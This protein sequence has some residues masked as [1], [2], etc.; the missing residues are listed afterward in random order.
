MDEKK[1]PMPAVESTLKAEEIPTQHIK[2]LYR[3]TQII[4]YLLLVI[5][6]LL[7]FRF[8]L[9]LLG[10]NPTAGFTQFITVITWPFAGPFLNV[11]RVTRVEGSVFEWTTILAMFFYFL[12]ATLIVKLFVMGKPVTTAEAEKKLPEQDKM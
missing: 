10:A 5:E 2:P 4:W 6:I 9:R 7:G 3:G 11:F 8:F 12:V 1:A